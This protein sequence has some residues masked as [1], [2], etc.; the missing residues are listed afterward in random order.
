MPGTYSGLVF[1]Q[2]NRAYVARTSNDDYDSTIRKDMEREHFRVGPGS[3]RRLLRCTRRPW[4]TRSHRGCLESRDQRRRNLR[5]SI[6]YE[7]LGC[8]LGLTPRSNS[9]SSGRSQS[10]TRASPSWELFLLSVVS[11]SAFWS[12]STATAVRLLDASL[13]DENSASVRD[14]FESFHNDR[15]RIGPSSFMKSCC[16]LA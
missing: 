14:T 13:E 16:A 10:S 9:F 15:L 1:V 8:A 6:S 7:E 11:R 2:G 4:V 5:V 3:V 12:R